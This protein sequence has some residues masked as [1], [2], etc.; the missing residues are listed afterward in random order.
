MNAWPT[1]VN[2]W[3]AEER[4]AAHRVIDSGQITMGEQV[5]AFE[6]EFARYVG[7]KYAVMAN[8]GSSAN[9]LALAAVRDANGWPLD[10]GFDAGAPA[11]AWATTYAP[12]A[13]HGFGLRLSDVDLHTLNSS[14]MMAEECVGPRT[15]VIVAVSILGNP[16]PLSSLRT[17]ANARGLVMIEDNCESLGSRL[18]GKHC[19]TFGDI[20]TFSTFFSHQVNTGEGGMIVTNDERLFT[21]A[22]C[23][24]AHGWTRDLPEYPTERGQ[25]SFIRPGYNLRPTE[26]AAAVGRVQLRRLPAMIEQRLRNWGCFT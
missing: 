2:S 8:S 18:N 19:G 24:R 4:E 20:G 9:L 6:E 5:E 22:R 16:A 17:I 23:M 25:Y 12:L 14:P 26:I 15:R 1:A 13:Q 11:V 3:G 21:L 10:H 7:A